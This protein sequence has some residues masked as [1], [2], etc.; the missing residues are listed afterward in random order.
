MN[1]SIV[2]LTNAVRYSLLALQAT[3]LIALT[4]IA[5]SLLIDNPTRSTLVWLRD[6]YGIQKEV[7][8][9]F[10]LVCAAGYAWS[11]IRLHHHRQFDILNA[12]AFGLVSAPLGIYAVLVWYLQ[13][14][15]NL[16]GPLIT[17]V[18]WAVLAAAMIMIHAF[19]L[20]FNLWLWET[21]QQAKLDG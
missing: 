12:L 2:K 11:M 5:I 4:V 8:P 15:I 19:N 6:S 20:T 17:P 18:I 9:I 10:M 13:S 1:V 7:F 3:P 21:E 16:G 14:Y